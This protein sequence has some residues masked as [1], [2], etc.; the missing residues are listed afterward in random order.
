MI[1]GIAAMIAVATLAVAGVVA[2]GIETSGR[3]FSK[4]P[5]ARAPRAHPLEGELD[6]SATRWR[7]SLIGAWLALTCMAVIA[8]NGIAPRSWL[9]LLVCGVVPPAML[10]WL[11]NE[12]R[13]LL[14]GSL[15]R[16]QRQL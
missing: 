5:R 10:L 16:R 2:C 1:G 13:P 11:W 14:L 3:S 12:D 7:W 8:I 6:M 9:L 4:Y 15:H